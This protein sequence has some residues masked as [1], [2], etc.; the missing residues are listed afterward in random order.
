MFGEMKDIRPNLGAISKAAELCHLNV[1]GLA[2]PE[3][4]DP[5]PKGTRSIVLLGP[6][7]PGFW[8]HVG[9]EPEFLESL[10]DPLDRW[11]T[12]IISV[13][14]S[15]F[16]GTAVFPFGGPPYAPFTAWAVRSGR[17][18]SSPVT[19]LVHDTAGLLVSYRGAIALPF[20]VEAA[21]TSARPCETCVGQP[22]L[23]ACP[24]SAL[25]SSG[26]D[27]KACHAF[28]DTS[29]GQDCMQQGCAVR[30]ACPISQTYGRL[31]EQSAH[32]MKAFH[33]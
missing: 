13:L 30:R 5:V 1:F 26:Y 2:S 14:A 32:H 33:S 21:N 28:L 10:P 25:T 22:C 8:L 15:D 7:E 17:A 31:S 4:E 27:L 29:E 6:H 18:W 24:V 3:A 19:L 9:G 16:G 23:A 12:R 11:S 20:A